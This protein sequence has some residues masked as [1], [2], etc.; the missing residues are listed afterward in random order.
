MQKYMKWT[1][2]LSYPCHIVLTKVCWMKL[3]CRSTK[4]FNSKEQQS[5]RR[6]APKNFPLN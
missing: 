6:E 4:A 5:F 1:P 3:K 2:T